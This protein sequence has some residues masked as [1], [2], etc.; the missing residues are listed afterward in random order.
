LNL[1]PSSFIPHFEN[2]ISFIL[3]FVKRASNKPL[4]LNAIRTAADCRQ[5]SKKCL[6][7]KNVENQKKV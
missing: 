1:F 3:F 6:V 7:D 5:P 4:D 2:A